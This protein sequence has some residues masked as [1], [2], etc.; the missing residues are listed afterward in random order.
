[1]VRLTQI[2]DRKSRSIL[3]FLARQPIAAERLVNTKLVFEDLLRPV[4]ARVWRS[5]RQTIYHR[6]SDITARSTGRLCM[7][8]EL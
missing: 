4:D 8:I 1:M 7:I 5:I 6:A 3:A 2:A